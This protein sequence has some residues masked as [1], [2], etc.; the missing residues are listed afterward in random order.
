MGDNFIYRLFIMKLK[1]HVYCYD[2]SEYEI[3]F[4][5]VDSMNIM[6]HGHY[7]KYLELARCAFLERINYTYDVMR[8]NGYGWPIV[9]LNLK[10]IRPALFRQ[11]ICVQLQ[12]VEYESCARFDYTIIDI[13]TGE[14]LTKGS[15]TQMAVDINTRETQFQTPLSFRKAVESYMTFQPR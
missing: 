10:Y 3:P 9:Q 7:V 1:K 15:T 6:W 13:A 4:F 14:R 2:E 11:K 8:K 5:D 12:L